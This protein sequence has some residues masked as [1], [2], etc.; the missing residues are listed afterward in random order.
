[1][2][3][4]WTLRLGWILVAWLFALGGVVGS[5]LNVVV[6]R[7]PRG[8]SI[9]HPGSACPACGHAIRWYDNMPIVSWLILGGRCRDCRVRIA[10][11]YPLVELATAVL[12]AGLFLIDARPR[13][14]AIAE[15]SAGPE[16]SGWIVLVR[17]GADLWLL[18]TLLCA[19]LIEYDGAR[20]PRRLFLAALLI[21]VVSAAVVAKSRPHAAET[22]ALAFVGLI[23]GCAIGRL[24]DFAGINGL[25]DRRGTTH[26]SAVRSAAFPLACVGAFWGWMPAL[27]IG[28]AAAIGI[29]TLWLL[30]KDKTA[31]A[32]LGWSGATLVGTVWVGTLTWIAYGAPFVAFLMPDA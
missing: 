24:F 23:A 29:A 15:G 10:P 31:P 30:K 11:R 22:I 21:A 19:A 5:F 13:I 32:R 25:A 16:A 14:I 20:V 18:S 3:I 27:A 26:P 17:Y 2:I 8:K 12:F 1:M 7:M 28:S 4:D 9:V 6:Y